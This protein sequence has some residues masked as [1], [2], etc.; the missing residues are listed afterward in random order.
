MAYSYRPADMIDYSYLFWNTP[1]R[2]SL[3]RMPCSRCT[4]DDNVNNIVHTSR[5]LDR[6]N[7]LP[8]V[9][10]VTGLILFIIL[11]PKH[12]AAVHLRQ[13]LDLG[14]IVP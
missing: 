7:Y 10:Q 2:K 11:H 13:R 1:K 8:H 14:I 3:E 6:E 9:Y 12:A 4:Q 5:S